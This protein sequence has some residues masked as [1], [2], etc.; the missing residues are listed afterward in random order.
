M[1]E[2]LERMLFSVH[3]H[4]TREERG[5]DRHKASATQDDE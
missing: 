5:P 3:L 4:V 1:D 2:E